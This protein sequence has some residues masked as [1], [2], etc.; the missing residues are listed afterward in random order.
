VSVFVHLLQRELHSTPAWDRKDRLSACRLGTV[1]RYSA[2]YA[3][4]SYVYR[5]RQVNPGS[6][7]YSSLANSTGAL[8]IWPE[9]RYYAE[10][11][12]YTPA[13]D[14]AHFTIEQSLVDQIELVLY[15]QNALNMSTNP[16]IAIGS[17]YS[18]HLPLP[19]Y[20]PAFLAH[21]IWPVCSYLE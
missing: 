11:A 3:L 13:D 14:F 15:I 1:V 6:G 10:E 18:K 7:F 4:T 5:H 8:Q 9:H 16:V 17:S 21:L 12:P 20:A 2:S 19:A